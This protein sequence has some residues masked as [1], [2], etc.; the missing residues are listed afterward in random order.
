MYKSHIKLEILGV[1]IQH[2]LK[3]KNRTPV[4]VV[5]KFLYL[6]YNQMYKVKLT[7]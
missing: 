2:A 3:N 6:P 1:I 5:L 4:N 7:S